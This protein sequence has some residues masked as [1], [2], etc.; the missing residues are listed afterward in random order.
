MSSTT[1]ERT[2]VREKTRLPMAGLLALFT[3]GFLGIINETIPAGL[4]PEMSRSLG[5]SESAVGQTVT[6]YALA[7]A[8]TAIPLN[9]LLKRWGR[10]TVLVS[11]L[12]GFA[13]ANAVTAVSD[14]FTV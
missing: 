3:A 11:A 14:D 7:T 9:V 4:L 2:D 13:L 1:H 12:T 10:R 5:L 8:F 6:V